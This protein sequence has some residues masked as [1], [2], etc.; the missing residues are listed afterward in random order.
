MAWKFDER[1]I[2]FIKYQLRNY[3]AREKGLLLKMAV[4]R[5]YTVLDLVFR[6]GNLSRIREEISNNINNTGGVCLNPKYET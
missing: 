5:V 6:W 2:K 4:Y 1:R 3:P